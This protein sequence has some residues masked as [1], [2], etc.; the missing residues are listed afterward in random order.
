MNAHKTGGNILQFVT[1][2][3]ASNGYPPT[4]EE[5]CE[6]IELGDR[7]VAEYYLHA[8]E[9]AGAITTLQIGPNLGT[10]LISPMPPRS[11]QPR[12]GLSRGVE[13]RG[14]ILDFISRFVARM[15]LPP[16]YREI[17]SGV[18]LSGQ[19]HA[20]YHLNILERKGR[21]SRVPRRPRTVR[22]VTYTPVKAFPKKQPEQRRRPPRLVKYRHRR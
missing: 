17:A 5:V 12:H 11:V 4:L 8:L 9:V 1:D 13:I 3:V 18:G 10:C 14:A 20:E 16:S 19:S 22:L 7:R 6:R 21:I 15:G 2:F